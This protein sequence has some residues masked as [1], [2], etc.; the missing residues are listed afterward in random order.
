MSIVHWKTQSTF[1]QKITIRKTPLLNVLKNQ[2]KEGKI[3]GSSAEK[4]GLG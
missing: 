3:T 4:G 1:F 2:K